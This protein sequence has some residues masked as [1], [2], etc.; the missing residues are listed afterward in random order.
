MLRDRGGDPTLRAFSRVQAAGTGDRGPGVS[1]SAARPR[2][3]SPPPAPRGPLAPR[4]L[5]S[6]AAL[7]RNPA[8]R[9]AAPRPRL[10]AAS[11]PGSATTPLPPPTVTA[12]S[13]ARARDQQPQPRLRLKVKGKN[14]DSV[15]QTHTE[16]KRVPVQEEAARRGLGPHHNGRRG[17]VTFRTSAG[18]GEPD[19]RTRTGGAA[20]SLPNKSASPGA[21]PK[22]DKLPG[23]S[24]GQARGRGRGGPHAPCPAVYVPTFE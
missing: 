14:P 10:P 19:Q 11:S 18:A 5:A 7:A 13:T 9:T 4:P 21:L 23:T 6:P 24:R 22:P 3:Q 20:V 15:L 12:R 8:T 16:G 2:P 17:G 1:P